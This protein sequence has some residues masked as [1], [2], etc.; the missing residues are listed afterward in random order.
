MNETREW[1]YAV[2]DLSTN[3]T[4]VSSVPCIVK[5]FYVNTTL[6]AHECLI[7]DN[8]TT[9]IRIPASTAAATTVDFHG[10]RFET[11]LIVDPHDS[12]TGELLIEY[13]ELERS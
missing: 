1:K 10:L 9:V 13:D 5:G 8:T 3:S 12:A 2:V 11:S 7:K 4:T 6:S